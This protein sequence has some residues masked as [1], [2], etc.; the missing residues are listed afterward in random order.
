MEEV[1]ETSKGGYK[2]QQAYIEKIEKQ[3]DE[4]KHRMTLVE[5]AVEAAHE[6]EPRLLCLVVTVGMNR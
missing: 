1:F 6:N 2:Y 3:D 4:L 5:I